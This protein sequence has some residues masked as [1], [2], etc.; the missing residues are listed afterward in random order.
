M[1]RELP[2]SDPYFMGQAILEAQKAYASGEIPV[3]AVIVKDGKIIARAHNE[4]EAKQ[5][6]TMH[7]EITAI[8][9]AS[10]VLG[11]WRLE[12]CSMYVTLEPCVMCAGA[13]VHARLKELHIGTSDPV[14]GAAGSIINVFGQDVLHYP[15]KLNF[16]LK[17]LECANLLKSF[18]R[19]LRKSP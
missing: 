13:I 2:Y 5:D 18:F 11:T 9:L 6:A 7:A 14:A 19:E 1:D 12:D 4:K 17:E 8:R 15:I 10:R 3:G 16:G